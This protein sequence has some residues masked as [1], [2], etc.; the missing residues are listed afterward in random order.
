MRTETIK[1]AHL[2]DSHFDDRSRFAECVRLHDWMADDW[3]RREVGLVLHAGDVFERKSTPT[4]RNAVATWL[5]RV[6]ER[7]PVVM[8]RGNHDAAGDLEIFSRLETEFPITV[9]EAAAVHRVDVIEAGGD[10]EAQ[11]A[12]ACMAWPSRAAILASLPAEL[13]HEGVEDVARLHMQNVLRG[14]G[15]EHDESDDIVLFC[16]HVMVRGSMTSTGQP[17]VGCDLELGL[18]DLAMVNADAYCLGH[19]HLPQEWT[20]GGS[21]VTFSG[22]P[23]RTAYGE[24]EAKGYRLLT[25]ERSDEGDGWHLASC[26]FI[27]APATPMLLLEGDYRDGVDEIAFPSPVTVPPGAEVRVRYTVD[28]DRRDAGRAAADRLREVLRDDGASRVDIEPQVRATVRARA[29]EVAEAKGLRQQLPALWR[30]QGDAPDDDRAPML[31]AMAEAVE[32]EVRC[33][34]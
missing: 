2:G 31:I 18:D 25:F 29:P 30:A 4:E 13:G 24:L 34:S 7:C 27:E 28:A 17:L 32:E 10:D 21:P 14:L 23:R 6:T 3:A 11:V 19:I 12:I 16:G 1:I 33:A 15:A 22:S 5:R 26:E 20:V 8:V 9:E